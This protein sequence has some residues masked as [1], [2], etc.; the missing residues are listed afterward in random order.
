[1]PNVWFLSGKMSV[2][3]GV[4]IAELAAVDYG[5]INLGFLIDGAAAVAST[6]SE[7]SVFSCAVSWQ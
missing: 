4:I 6:G 2:R 3:C 1:M 7:R 5:V